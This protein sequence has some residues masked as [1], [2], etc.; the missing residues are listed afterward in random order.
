[1]RTKHKLWLIIFLIL[2]IVMSIGIFR[3]HKV[4]ANP[5]SLGVTKEVF[6]NQNQLIHAKN[7]DFMI[8]SAH[9]SKSKG[10]IM[11]PVELTIKQTGSANY[12][13]KKNN[14]NF[15][16]NMWLNIPYSISTAT[17]DVTDKDN[18]RIHKTKHLLAAKQPIT[19][20]FMTTQANY[21]LRNQKMRF[22]FLV[23][24]SNH[25]VKYSLLLE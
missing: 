10:Q 14:P 5:K 8:C 24:V 12:G 18:Q 21:A 4:N 17:A 23:P 11:V 13:Y 7:V 9:V 22:S 20:H 16:E 1:M 25:Y 6:I 2:I 19:L 15:L 3:Y